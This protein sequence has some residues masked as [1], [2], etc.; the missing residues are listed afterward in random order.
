MPSRHTGAVITLTQG[1]GEWSLTL[2][3]EESAPKLAGS[4]ERLKSLVWPGIVHS[5]TLQNMA[6]ASHA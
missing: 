2:W 3:P 6:C 4:D 5:K 1:G